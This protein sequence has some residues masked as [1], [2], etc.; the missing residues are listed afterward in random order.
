MIGKRAGSGGKFYGNI[1]IC[2]QIVNSIADIV[3]ICAAAV[4]N[5]IRANLPA[6]DGVACLGCGG[7]GHLAAFGQAAAA[8]NRKHCARGIRL[9]GD[10]NRAVGIALGVYGVAFAGKRVNRVFQQDIVL[11]LQGLNLLRIL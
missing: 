4:C 7:E 11:L 8:G 10:G 2:A 1:G 6:A 5:V 3:V 9:I